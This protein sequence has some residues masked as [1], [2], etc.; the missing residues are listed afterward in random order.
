MKEK[1]LFKFPKEEAGH[2]FI[3]DL[4]KDYDWRVNILRASIDYNAR[5]FMLMEVVS[6]DENYKSGMAFVGSHNVEVIVIEAA[7]HINEDKC[8]DCGACTAVCPADALY[9]DKDASLHFDKDLCLD[10][11]LC[12]TA[13][14]ARAIE[15]V[16]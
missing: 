7:I 16:L 6:T 11:K 9:L 1:L 8:L 14:P 15:A 10:C 13:C 3:Y 2:A 12:I 4:I 5:G